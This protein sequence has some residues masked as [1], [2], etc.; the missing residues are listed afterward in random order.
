MKFYFLPL[1]CIIGIKDSDEYMCVLFHYA[2]F[3]F[4]GNNMVELRETDPT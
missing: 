4:S 2:Y 3:P 1:N